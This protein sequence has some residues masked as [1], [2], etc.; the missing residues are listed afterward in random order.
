M[1]RNAIVGQSGGPTA[2]INSSLVGVF[3]AAKSRGA[4]HVYGMRYGVKGLLEEQVVDLSDTLRDNLDIEILKRTPA[5]YLGSLRAMMEPD[6]EENRTVFMVLKD[7]DVERAVA[8][9]EEVA[10]SFN[11][12][13]SGIAFTLPVDFVKGIQ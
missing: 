8:A 12:P 5:S 7:E 2:V 13:N 6:R 1:G 4:Q 10:G 9:V 3:Q 11:T